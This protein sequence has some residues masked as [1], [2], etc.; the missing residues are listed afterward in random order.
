MVPKDFTAA[1]FGASEYLD[2]TGRSLPLFHITRDG[3]MLLAM[4]YTGAKA[5]SLK[6]HAGTA[7]PQ[8]ANT[9]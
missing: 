4:G 2:S 3:F 1:N 7:A 6:V 8:P 9:Y 5:M